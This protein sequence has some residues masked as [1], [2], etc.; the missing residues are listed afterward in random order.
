MKGKY[1]IITIGGSAGSLVVLSSILDGLPDL[2]RVPVVIILHR[3]RNVESEMGHLL[4]A[5]KLIR[6][7]EDKEAIIDYHFY[8]AP[9]NYHL[10]IEADKSFMLDYSEL[11]NYSRPSIDMT[12]SCAAEVYGSRAL[13]ILLSGANK[14]GAAGLCQIIA[15]G[16]T[17]IAQDPQMAAFEVMPQSAIDL[18]QNVK[19]LTIDEII[20]FIISE[21]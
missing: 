1:D 19:V 2:M 11:V 9:Q 20:K 14:D 12:F 7:P 13:G 16:G 3:L 17:G 21:T 10:M 5:K 4:S 8:L 6:E 15:A 18:C